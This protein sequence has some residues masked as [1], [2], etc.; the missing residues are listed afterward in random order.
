MG[1][2]Y[3]KCEKMFVVSEKIERHIVQSTEDA[4]VS[5]GRI[6]NGEGRTGGSPGMSS[7]SY[8]LCNTAAILTWEMV[9]S[10]RKVAPKR[11]IGAV[12]LEIVS[13]PTV[14]GST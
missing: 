8:Y 4:F 5:N 11:E 14:G 9:G 7:L 2:I 1:H 13:Y 10:I 6:T 12:I 3:T